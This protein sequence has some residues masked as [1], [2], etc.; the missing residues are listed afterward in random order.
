MIVIATATTT[1]MSA[2]THKDSSAT[3]FME[4]TMISQD[5]MKSVVMAPLVTL[6]SAS[7]PRST[8][9]ALRGSRVAAELVPDLFGTLIAEV[10]AA[11][12]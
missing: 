5:R 6:A 2:R 12:P 8:A 7:G 10:G 1:K 3:S 9:G 11:E 4:M